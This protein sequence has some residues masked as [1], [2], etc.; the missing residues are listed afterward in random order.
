MAKNDYERHA[1]ECL[2]LAQQTTDPQNRAVLIEMAQAWLR[3]A[4]QAEKNT[5][6]DLVYETPPQRDRG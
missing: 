5:R 3:L 2:L 1:A 6:T 4:D